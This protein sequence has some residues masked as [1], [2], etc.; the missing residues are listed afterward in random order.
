M[1]ENEVE[2]A[3]RSGNRLGVVVAEVDGFAAVTDGAGAKDRQLLLAHMS[4]ALR[5][6]PRKIDLAARL[7]AGRFALVLPYTDE[8]GAYLLAERLREQ[9]APAGL[10]V[11]FGVAG[12][13]RSGATSQQVFQAAELALAEAREA[14]GDRVM[15]LQ[16]APSSARVEIDVSE[17]SERS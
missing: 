3:R 15:M 10:R 9:T 17:L 11:S 2:R 5:T 7:G 12:F 14:G 13:P 8:H 4:E 6:T 1:L 16:R